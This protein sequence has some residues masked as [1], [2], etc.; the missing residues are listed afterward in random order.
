ME[1]LFKPGKITFLLDGGAGSSAK[2]KVASYIGETHGDDFH[3]VCNSFSSNAAHWVK[4]DDGRK[5]MYKTFNS[6]AYNVYIYEKMYIGPG[7][8]MELHSFLQELEENKIHPKKVGVHP[9]TVI[10]QDADAKYEKGE[11][12]FDGEEAKHLGTMATGSTCSGVGAATAKRVLRR[13]TVLYAKDV[14]ELKEFICDVDGEILRRLGDGQAGFMEIAQGYQLSLMHQMFAPYTT[15]RNVTTAGAL[16]DMFLPPRVA[17]PVVLNFRTFPIRINSN[18]FIGEDGRH[19]TWD[20]VQAGV[21]HKVY[22]GNS[23]PW[24]PDQKEITW[25]ELTDMSGSETKIMEITSK[26]KLPRRVATFSH[27][28]LLDAITH[29]DTGHDYFITVNFADYVDCK[30]AGVRG[31][32]DKLTPKMEKWISENIRGYKDKLWLVG[33]GPLTMDVVEMK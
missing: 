20:E 16:S 29:N 13:P 14:P 31:G 12:G 5:F 2:G 19:L 25:D 28:N 33:T 3:F 15:F 8:A 32:V 4:L 22:E 27:W 10:V 17:G 11:I 30:M 9:L 21:P 24:Y 7:S 1:G 18:K 26:T 6:C 23:G